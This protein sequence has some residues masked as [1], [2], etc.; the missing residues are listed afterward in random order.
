MTTEIA[1]FTPKT[2]TG[3]ASLIDFWNCDLWDGDSHLGY[4]DSNDAIQFRASK[5]TWL[6][7]FDAKFPNGYV[8]AYFNAESS[9]YYLVS[10]KLSSDLAWIR[11]YIDDDPALFKQVNGNNVV[12]AAMANLNE[13]HHS[14]TIEQLDAG[15]FF[16]DISDKNLWFHSLKV[17]VV[18]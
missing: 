15:G 5:T 14:V 6:E 7:G 8:Q 16:W 12:V 10:A 13:G 18:D 4:C 17:E 9:A 3:T 2:K 1:F 11:M